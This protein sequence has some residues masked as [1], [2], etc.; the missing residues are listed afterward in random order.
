MYFHVLGKKTE[1]DGAMTYAHRK[2]NAGQLGDGRAI[3]SIL[4]SPQPSDPN[5]TY[6]FVVRLFVSSYAQKLCMRWVYHPVSR[7]TPHARTTSVADTFIR[8]GSF[9]ALSPSRAMFFFG[10]GRQYADYE[11]LRILGER[12]VKRVLK[13]D[14]V[15]LD[16]CDAWGKELVLEVARRNA[17][18]VAAWQAYG[19]IHG[20]INT[21]KQVSDVLIAGLTIDYGPYAFMDVFDPHHIGNH[22]DQEGRYAYNQQPN[23]ILYACR[24][25]LDALASLIGAEIALGNKAVQRRWAGNVNDETVSE[26]RAAEI[27]EVGSTMNHIIESTRA[28]EYGMALR[29]HLALHRVDSSAQHTIFQPLL[30]MMEKHRLDFRGIFTKLAAGRIHCRIAREPERLD[31]GRATEEWLAWLDT[32]TARIKFEETSGEW[33]E[34][35][36]EARER[37]ANPRF[38][39]RQL[40]PEEAIQNIEDDLATGKHVLGKVMQMTCSP[41]NLWG[42]EGDMPDDELSEEEREERRNCGLGDR[43]M[44]GFQCSCSS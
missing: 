13:L 1:K 15:N 5:T 43:R 27:G 28:S 19:F 10:G 26:W 3:I 4:V 37:A 39:L 9:E 24:A 14:I 20:V 35:F 8:I 2:T 40:L 6:V 21:D 31:T 30:D 36:E 23:M 25:L 44:L 22:S 32:Y 41:F 33:G 38:V 16:G 18:M 42:R 17:K 12:T 7:N 29:R 11:A 34:D